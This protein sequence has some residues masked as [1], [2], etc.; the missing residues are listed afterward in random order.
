[1]RERDER[2]RLPGCCAAELL[3]FVRLEGVLPLLLGHVLEC[4]DVLGT[5]SDEAC[6]ETACE[7]ARIPGA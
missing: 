5:A 2:E 6:A 7:I 3:D 4:D 1:M